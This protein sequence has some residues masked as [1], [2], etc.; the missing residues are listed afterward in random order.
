MWYYNRMRLKDKILKFFEKG[1]IHFKSFGALIASIS[2]RLDEDVKDVSSCINK[3]LAE[4]VII[5]SGKR[6]LTLSK[7]LGYF[8]GEICGNAKGYAF[9]KPLD[10]DKEDCFIAA[11][12]LRGALDNDKVLYKILGDHAEVIKILKRANS[13]LV[14]AVCDEKSINEKHK[15]AKSKGKFV[16]ADND[17]FSKP[18][19]I[20][21]R[22]LRGAKIGDKVVVDLTYQPENS[23]ETPCGRVMEIL[24]GNEVENAIEGV[25]VEHNIPKT[26]STE[27]INEAENLFV[28][29]EKE[30]EKRVDLTKKVIFTIDGADAKDLD[31][32]ISIE[33]TKDGYELGV[34]IADVGQF[35]QIDT[36]LDEEA[37]YRATSVYFPN[38]VYPMLPKKLS[39]DL[40]SLN[41]NE[42]KLALSVIMNVDETGNVK[43]YRIFESIIKSMQRLTYDQAYSFLNGDK[44][45]GVVQEVGNALSQMIKLSEILSTK[46]KNAGALDFDI[47]ECE[48]EFDESGNVVDVKGRERNK[49]HKLIENF[50]VLCNETVAKCFAALEMPFVYRVHECPIKTKFDEVVTLINGMGAKLKFEK[51]ITPVYV[52]NILKSLEKEDYY[53]IASKLILRA[54]EKAVYSPECEGHFGLALDYYCHFTSPIRRYPDLTI[55]RIIKSILSLN[56]DNIIKSEQLNLLKNKI[57]LKNQYELEEFVYDSSL[58]SSERERNADEAERDVDDIY[59]AQIMSS[60]IGEIFEARVSG[61]ANFGIFVELENT[62]EG[63]IKLELLPE[64]DYNYDSKQLALLGKKHK[65]KIG[66]KLK[67]K[68]LAANP[69]LKRI[70]FAL[71]NE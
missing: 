66:D 20:P 30:K 16:I 4:G 71:A 60:H 17:K 56:E 46:R 63:L 58:R 8:I 38:K 32:A 5:E 54:L 70:D 44:N 15:K 14:G 69:T 61:V 26:F 59:K 21:E 33:K 48:F 27:T 50:M 29:W 51:K 13:S 65:F 39:N 34:H 68:V 35:V 37:F 40:C 67:V 64:D 41:A 1:Q 2:D 3:L 28:N 19:F 52:Q 42:P 10:D 6:A 53:D 25:L 11:K 47:P 24:N 31:D 18:I 22:E 55:H 23:H 9:V 57:K 45:S 43:N 49:S 62:S 7:N 12:D 36:P